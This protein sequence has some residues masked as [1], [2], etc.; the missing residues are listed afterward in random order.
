MTTGDDDDHTAQQPTSGAQSPGWQQ[1]SGG[2]PPPYQ[3]AYQPSGQ[4]PPT[5][6]PPRHPDALTA[7]VLGAA[8]LLILPLLG[9]FAWH[10]GAK[11]GREMAAQPGRWSG[12]DLA[13]IGMILGIVATVLCALFVLFFVFVLMTGVGIFAGTLGV[14]GSLTP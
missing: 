3:P 4:Y 8:S 7:I 6:G 9:P 5:F 11:A 10:I 1:G 13:R 12:D 2:Q 14:F